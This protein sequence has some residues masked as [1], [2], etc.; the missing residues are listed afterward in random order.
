M[1]AELQTRYTKTCG[2]PGG[3]RTRGAKE[4]V[5]ERARSEGDQRDM[6]RYKYWAKAQPD[7]VALACTRQLQAV[8]S[9]GVGRARSPTCRVGVPRSR[10]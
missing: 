4:H 9:Q 8:G 7:D 10:F 6:A 5:A 1:L 3:E 2:E